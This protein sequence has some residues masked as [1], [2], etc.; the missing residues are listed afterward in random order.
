MLCVMCNVFMLSVYSS[1]FSEILW[2]S[3]S[4]EQKKSVQLKQDVQ[5]VCSL[6]ADA[7]K[8]L[9]GITWGVILRD[10]EWV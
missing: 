2:R 5:H 7:D 8:G 4:C 10:S 9:L 6:K 1:Y 3:S